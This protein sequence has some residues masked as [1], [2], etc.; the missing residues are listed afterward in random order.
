AGADTKMTGPS[1]LPGP[2]VVALAIASAI[3]DPA[4]PL[5]VPVGQDVMIG[6]LG[7]LSGTLAARCFGPTRGRSPSGAQLASGRS[8]PDW[9]RRGRPLP[10]RHRGC[11]A[12]TTPGT[13]RRASRK[14]DLP[15]PG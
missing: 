9:G 7:R 12:E 13:T 15:R 2:E 8:P 14:P 11:P 10:G 1:G 4:T 6:L 3:E 5:R